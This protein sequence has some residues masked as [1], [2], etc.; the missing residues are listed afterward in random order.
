MLLIHTF[1]YANIKNLHL[2]LLLHEWFVLYDNFPLPFAFFKI[3][4]HVVSWLLDVR[5]HW[6]ITWT[7]NGVY[8]RGSSSYLLMNY[9]PF[10]VVVNA[11]VYRNIWLRYEVFVF[12][13]IT[14]KWNIFMSS[15]Q[16]SYDGSAVYLVN[17]SLCS[18]CFR[19]SFVVRLWD[20]GI[21]I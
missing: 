16:L 7:P 1:L 6:M 17:Y 3:Y 13:F 2:F 12:T 19:E 15:V 21:A 18:Y 10:L 20:Q 11:V 14:I 4:R 8:F 5:N 9:F